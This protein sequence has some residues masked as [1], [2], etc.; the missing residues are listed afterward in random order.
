MCDVIIEVPV[1]QT[2]NEMPIHVSDYHATVTLD[3]DYDGYYINDIT[4]EG[5]RPG[6]RVRTHTVPPTS[7]LWREIAGYAVTQCT[8]QLEDAWANWMADKPNRIADQ[9]RA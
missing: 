7:T 8:A 6:S 5:D 2:I 3:A 9:R 4:V 1:Y